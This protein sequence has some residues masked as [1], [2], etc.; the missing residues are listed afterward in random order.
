MLFYTYMHTSTIECGQKDVNYSA[1]EKKLGVRGKTGSKCV[2]LKNPCVE[3]TELDVLT[4]VSKLRF[5]VVERSG[6]SGRLS[7]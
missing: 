4:L 7:K 6:S 5:T 2:S 1:K 3:H